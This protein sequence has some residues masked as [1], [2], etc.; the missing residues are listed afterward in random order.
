M[1]ADVIINPNSGEIYW[2]DGTGTPQSISIRGDSQNK[3]DII[4]YSA[5]FSPGGSGVGTFVIATFNDN[6]GGLVAFAP[7]STGNE[8]GS[9]TLRW[10]P[11]LTT[12]TI[13]DSSSTLGTNTSSLL[14]GLVQINGGIAISGSA[15][16]GGTILFFNRTNSIFYAGFRASSSL[17]S[18]TIYTLPLNYP[19]TGTSVLRSDTSGNLD[20][21]PLTATTAGSA[22]TATNLSVQ[23]IGNLDA[24]HSLLVT[25]SVS[26]AGSAVSA[27]GTLVFNPFTDILSVSGISVTSAA[28]STSTTS[29]ALQVR[30]GVGITGNAFIGGTI[31]VSS[32][33]TIPNGGTNA[34]SFGQ[35]AGFIYYDGVN[36]R[37]LAATGA[38]INFTNGYYQFDNR[39][40]A[41]SFFAGGNQMPNG[42]G[43]AGRVT[44]WSGNNTIGSDAE[45]TYDAT[46]NILT[47]L[48]NINAIGFTASGV[49]VTSALGATSTSSGALTVTG[50]LALGGNAFIGGTVNITNTTQ[51]A[52]GSST[53]GAVVV[54][55]SV[56]IGGSVYIGGQLG[57]GGTL[58]YLA[59]G[60][61]AYFSGNNNSYTQVIVHN[62]NSG[63]SAS[64]DFI[65]S[66]DSATD[67]TF[68]GDF[69]MNSSGW[70]ATTAAYNT[71]NAVYL[72]SN[73]GDLAIGSLTSN[74]VRFFFNNGAVDSV[75]MGGAGMTIFYGTT[76]SSTTSGAL[77]I[78]GGLGITGNAFI[79]GST[80]LTGIE[81]VN[82]STNATSTATG[83]LIVSGGLALGSNAFIGGTIYST[84][85][86]WFNNVT[87]STSP[88]TGTLIVG[89]GVGVGQS[90]AIG[91]RLLLFNGATNYTGFVSAASGVT[92]YTLPVSTPAGTAVSVLQSTHEGVM[93]WVPMV[94]GSSSGLATTAQNVQV[95]LIG[96]PNS[97]HSVLLTPT[98]SSAGSAVSGNGTLTYNPSTDVLYTP[99]LAV[100]SAS[101]GVSYLVAATVL[102]GGLG[103]GDNITALNKI[104][105]GVSSTNV[106]R[107][108]LYASG[109]DVGFRIYEAANASQRINLSRNA[110]GSNVPALAF[111]NGSSTFA[112]TGVAIGVPD[113]S[114]TQV[115]AIYASD[116]TSGNVIRFTV[117]GGNTR[118]TTNEIALGR[119][120][121]GTATTSILRGV[122]A[123]GTDI[124]TSDFII[125][126]GRSTGT[127]TNNGIRLQVATPATSTGSGLNAAVDVVKINTAQNATSTAS[128]SLI[129]YGGFGISGNAFIGG[130]TL[131]SG[132]SWINNST[133]ATT[134]SAGALIVAGGLALGSN[135]IIGGSTVQSG[136]SWIN[137]STNATSTASGA[138][139]VAGG[140]ALAANAF[141]GGTVYSTSTAWFNNSTPSISTSTG[142]LIVN[143][144]V[145]IGGSL[146]TNT[147]SNSSISGV[148]HLNSV[149]TAGSWAATAI[150]T[151]Y[152]GHGAIPVVSKGDILVGAGNTWYNL[153]YSAS[154]SQVLTVDTATAFG[155]KW[156][157]VTAA[158]SSVSVA[159]AT[160]NT[161]V[162]LT[163][164][165]AD[166]G[167]GFALST[168]TALS[169]NPSVSTLSSTGITATSI[170][171]LNYLIPIG[172][173][174]IAWYASDGTTQL[175]GINTSNG[176]LRSYQTTNATSTASAAL[177]SSGGL[178]LASNAFIGGS[179]HITGIE[180][181]N[182]ATTSISTSTGALIVSGG[183]GIGGSLYV[184]TSV[185]SNISGIFVLNGVLS[186]SA[187]TATSSLTATN[188]RTTASTLNIVDSGTS[189]TVLNYNGSRFGVL[190]D[191]NSTA[192]NNGGL[193]VTGGAGFGASINVNGNIGV[194][195]GFEIR[196]YNPA[197]NAYAGFD[198]TG[199]GS[200]TYILPPSSPA[201][202][203]SVLQSTAG[204]VMSWVPMATGS[205]SPGGSNSQIQFNSGGTF[206][207]AVG[208][209]YE[210]TLYL[211]SIA[212]TADQRAVTTVGLRLINHSTVSVAGV[213]QRYSPALELVGKTIQAPSTEFFNRFTTDVF[214]AVSS[215][216]A[217]QQWKY[218]YDTGT[219]S[220]SNPLFIIHSHKGIGIG[221][222]SIT[223]QSFFRANASQASELLY[224]LP[225]AYPGTG[226][227]VL[228]SDTTG[229]LS[230]VPMTTG[231]SGTP[232]GSTR[233][234]QYN[235]GGVF[236]GASGFEYQTVGNAVTVNIFAT[237]G[238]GLTS[239]LSI[240]TINGTTTRIGIGLTNPAFELEIR[241]EISATNKS[242]VIDHPTKPDMKLR[243]GS[244]EGPE[245]GVYVR[246]QLFGTNVIETPDYWRGLVH[247]DSYTIHLTPIGNYQQLY[248]DKIQDYKVYVGTAST[249]EINCFYS[250]W[251]ERKDISKLIVEY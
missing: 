164:T 45:F 136:I 203:S 210:P 116:G 93:S 62:H 227:S 186:G 5:S 77:Q 230:W 68:F 67:T 214:G 228:S 223:F 229:N 25:P 160:G 197:D 192:S 125:Q 221:Q 88:T 107:S 211:T 84:S 82:N 135:A 150:T 33:L 3:I 202:G 23:L 46:N 119:D 240:N 195:S 61:V 16:I 56:G 120:T 64:S 207:G 146:Y 190:I 123:T 131:Q 168:S 83:A 243:Y 236:G 152:G 6:S 92:T 52:Y 144:G 237:A 166:T 30:G 163:A 220:Y 34:S 250:V 11:Y 99:G 154:N 113:A 138:L 246:G 175:M 104:G 2:N 41:T 97:F 137:N 172:G 148:N 8:L 140:L 156:A 86:G 55:G 161:V 212:S 54:A 71:A 79:G 142:T 50:G 213:Q 208:I 224:V 201:T 40:Y 233:Q 248:I 132:V 176:W 167:S 129:V 206:A 89:G 200:T 121:S 185:P 247:D 139:I 7:G 58:D 76:A 216:A 114:S 209:S 103:V 177:V 66:N 145:G 241:G 191:A 180:W 49:A 100:T 73:S 127:G 199:S 27:N 242:F 95:T 239:G 134:S 24:Q 143:G 53:S 122:N 117:L 171:A 17:A 231:G 147:G 165:N 194:R 245:N 232:G 19:G 105:V 35:S 21:A 244:L 155:L 15:S 126:A 249:F 108:E 78:R 80:H 65:V 26:S 51:S 183:V 106:T 130:S 133:N 4:G 141:I 18:T 112:T 38:T 81:W 85:T 102:T 28:N 158:A 57:V 149:I 47:V 157:A 187:L 13:S 12:T 124:S 31:N 110:A 87:A 251:A 219:A 10:K 173:N 109:T 118:V 218:S 74:A 234:I 217:Q 72:V 60:N 204:G 198:F 184:S 9:S 94:A 44:I 90:V 162:F 39:V 111:Q 22:T 63:N 32:P 178:A 238:G 193:V 179:T 196:L 20:W 215:Y 98:V 222:S 96:N 181:I 43:T 128:G 48:G 1:P 226:T 182:N 75:A 42:S 37:L 153:P 174:N 235:N 101:T 29:G 115:L 151:A 36:V 205:G 14:T 169:Y 59:T 159:S 188:I 225:V 170:R 189:N 69:G 70:A 91:G